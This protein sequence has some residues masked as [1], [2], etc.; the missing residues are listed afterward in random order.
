MKTI[1]AYLFAVIFYLLSRAVGFAIEITCEA[2]SICTKCEPK[3]KLDLLYFCEI[4]Y[5]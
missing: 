1:L 3:I 5:S 2:F 4:M